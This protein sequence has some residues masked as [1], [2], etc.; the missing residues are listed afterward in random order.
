MGEPSERWA[1]YP[2]RE[3][4]FLL[5]PFA[6]TAPGERLADVGTGNG[7]L[8]LAAARS[9]A[10]VVATDL[11]RRALMELRR[12]ALAER[13]AVEVVRT[14]LLA[15]LGRFDRIVANPPYLPTIVG[16]EDSDRGDRLAL[17]GGED[18]LRVTR[19]LFR[20]WADHLAPG[21]RA[22]VVA[23]TLQDPRG[24]G[25]IVAEWEAHGGAVARVAER[26]LEGERLAVLECR[27]DARPE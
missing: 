19:R 7:V 20:S 26:A 14:D 24:F 22:Y 27:W 3:D 10:R 12:R 6:R 23:S 17:D 25:E 9:G 8:A 1:V 13:L 16:G 2:P 5:L 4:T 18:G 21:G 15:G 11:N